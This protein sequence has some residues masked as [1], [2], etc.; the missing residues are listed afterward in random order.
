MAKSTWLAIIGQVT[1]RSN[2][3]RQTF[4]TIGQCNFS[5]A[6][7]I[8]RAHFLVGCNY[9]DCGIFVFDKNMKNSS[10]EFIISM[11]HLHCT[12]KCLFIIFEFQ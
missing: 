12:L 9:V 7:T 3:Y 8:L 11:L 4:Y 2:R 1:T 5:L 10:V 6:H